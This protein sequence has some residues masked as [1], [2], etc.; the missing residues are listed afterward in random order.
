MNS[1]ISVAQSGARLMSCDLKVFYLATPMENP[2]FMK[3][4]LKFF[5]ED[6]INKYALRTLVHLDGCVYIKIKKGMYGLK[7]VAL[8]VYTWLANRL[9]EAGYI[10]ITGSTCM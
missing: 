9:R 1:V 2:E 7:K 5:P 8:L 4:N 3:V 6:I 10:Y